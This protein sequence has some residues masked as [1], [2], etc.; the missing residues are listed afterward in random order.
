MPD[1]LPCYD[2]LCCDE[3]STR[4]TIFVGIVPAGSLKH[5]LAQSDNLRSCQLSFWPLQ[6]GERKTLQGKITP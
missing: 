1:S 6:G 5:S 4:R 3:N 2:S